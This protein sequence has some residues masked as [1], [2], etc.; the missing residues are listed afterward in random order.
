MGALVRAARRG[1]LGQPV[2][3]ERRGAMA[4]LA[5]VGLGLIVSLIAVE[6]ASRR[7]G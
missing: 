3:S 5:L 6:T 1:A 7:K 4:R 2:D